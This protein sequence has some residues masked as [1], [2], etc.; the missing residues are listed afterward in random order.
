[1]LLSTVLVFNGVL[2]PS[3]KIILGGMFLRSYNSMHFLFPTSYLCLPLNIVRH[4][5]KMGGQSLNP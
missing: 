4:C 1:M 2:C 3:R 5:Q